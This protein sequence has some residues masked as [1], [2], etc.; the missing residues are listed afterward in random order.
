MKD[1]QSLQNN[2]AV[3]IKPV[4]LNELAQESFTE[5]SIKAPELI[6]RKT[7]TDE[8]YTNLPELLQVLCSNFYDQN[9]KDVFFVGALGV[10]SGILTNIQ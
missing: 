6:E 1:N 2:G 5:E 10:V 9:D 3:S 4:D 7:F 8:V